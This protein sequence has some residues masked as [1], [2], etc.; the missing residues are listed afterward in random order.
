MIQ[1]CNAPL[2]SELKIYGIPVIPCKSFCS[3]YWGAAAAE[4]HTR[5]EVEGFG[6]AAANDITKKYCC[7]FYT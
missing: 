3:V 7:Y 4:I 6:V 2:D 5:E 1:L